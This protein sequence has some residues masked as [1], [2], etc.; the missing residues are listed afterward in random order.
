MLKLTG[1]RP[2]HLGVDNGRLT[3][4]P[5]KP[6]CVSSQAEPGDTVHYVT[7]LSFKGDAKAALKKLAQI[8]DDMPRTQIIE[9]KATYLYAEFST[10]LLGF[11]DDVEF[12]CDGKVIHVR[13]ASRLGYSDLGAN[14]KRIEAIRTAFGGA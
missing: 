1:K 4:P 5:R 6:N 11:T 10:P 8:I 7:P 14:R 13:S 12:Y 3:P 9:S 2:R